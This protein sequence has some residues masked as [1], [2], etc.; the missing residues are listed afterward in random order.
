MP[1]IIAWLRKA[2]PGIQVELH[3]SDSFE[4]LLF[5]EADIAICMYPPH[6]LDIIARKIGEIAIGLV[7]GLGLVR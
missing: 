2:A 6:E 4:N 1:A 5:R 3:P 7:A